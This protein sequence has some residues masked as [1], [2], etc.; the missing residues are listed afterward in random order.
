MFYFE[1]LVFS[2]YDER[3]RFAVEDGSD[4]IQVRKEIDNI[5][6]TQSRLT[7]KEGF[8]KFRSGTNRVSPYKQA[9]DMLL[10]DARGA[11]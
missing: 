11:R 4:S 3:V 6:R 8:S 10:K 9:S 5:R 7:D 2:L 1:I